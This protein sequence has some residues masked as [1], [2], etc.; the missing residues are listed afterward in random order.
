M[1]PEPVHRIRRTHPH[2]APTRNPSYYAGARARERPFATV[3]RRLHV[4]D[5]SF[6]HDVRVATLRLTREAA[7]WRDQGR[8]Y[9]VLLDG[10]A[11][12]RIRPGVTEVYEI[13]P[14]QHQLRLKIDFTGSDTLA[15][16][17]RDAETVEFRCAPARAA[18]KSVLN[19]FD[20]TPWIDL[21]RVESD[22]TNPV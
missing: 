10:Q 16:T 22:T 3:A 20:R 7:L 9:K 2:P 6:G 11:R 4:L 12:G 17:V 19:L 1:G 18:V 21:W 14:G 8:T 15:F 5:L 13:G